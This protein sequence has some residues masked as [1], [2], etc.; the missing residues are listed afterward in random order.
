MPNIV[1]DWIEDSGCAWNAAYVTLLRVTGIA[2]QRST[3]LPTFAVI[4]SKIKWCVTKAGTFI[5]FLFR[6]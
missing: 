3:F 4:T 6:V 1:F 2:N 5:L